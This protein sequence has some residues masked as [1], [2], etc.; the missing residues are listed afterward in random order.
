MVKEKALGD[1]SVAT[2]PSLCLAVWMT[3]LLLVYYTKTV[4]SEEAF[5]NIDDTEQWVLRLAGSWVRALRSPSM[6]VKTCVM[7]T[8]LAVVSTCSPSSR[9]ASRREGL[10]PR[11]LSMIPFDRLTRLTHQRLTQERA[12]LPVASEYLQFLLETIALPVTC[13]LPPSF[14]PR[15]SHPSNSALSD[16]SNAALNVQLDHV[17]TTAVKVPQQESDEDGSERYRDFEWEAAS[18]RLFTDSAAGWETWTGVVYQEV[19]GRTV[20]GTGLP[21]PTT[22][23]PSERQEAPPELLVGCKVVGKRPSKSRRTS[24][25][26]IGADVLRFEVDTT[27]RETMS[28]HDGRV[29]RDESPEIVNAFVSTGGKEGEESPSARSMKR[30][31]LEGVSPKSAGGGGNDSLRPDERLGTV[32]SFAIW[33]ESGVEAGLGSARVVRWEEDGS[34][35]TV[36]WDT[37]EGVYDVTHVRV[38]ADKVIRYSAHIVFRIVGDLSSLD[39][40]VVNTAGFHHHFLEIILYNQSLI[41]RTMTSHDPNIFYTPPSVVL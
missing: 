7:R 13:R 18:G 11:L 38:T 1:S 24:P 30:R 17:S 9:A 14:L 15:T 23:R 10:G 37:D 27:W 19:V 31:L 5:N 6:A 28:D 32:I 3:N 29:S 40:F 20:D 21:P 34:S 2:L 41:V 4:H 8:L 36:R 12:N 22:A 16:S 39:T 35:E 25:P 33:E 26:D